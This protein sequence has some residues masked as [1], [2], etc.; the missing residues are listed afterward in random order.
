MGRFPVRGPTVQCRVA[1]NCSGNGRARGRVTAHSLVAHNCGSPR[2]WPGRKRHARRRG[3]VANGVGGGS[4]CAAPVSGGGRSNT[5][6]PRWLARQRSLRGSPAPSRGTTMRKVDGGGGAA[7]GDLH[8]KRREVRRPA[9]GACGDEREVSTTAKAE[10]KRWRGAL[11]RAE[12]VKHG[13]AATGAWRARTRAVGVGKAAAASDQLFGRDHGWSDRRCRER[14]GR[15]VDDA[16]MAR[17]TRMAALPRPV[18]Q[19]ETTC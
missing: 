5:A 10:R 18:H 1:Y 4:G 9:T 17:R 11:T 3:G 7:G 14:H 13:R 12:A 2:L 16:F 8:R 19:V 15:P 6:S